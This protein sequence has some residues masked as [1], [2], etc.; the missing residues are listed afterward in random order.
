MDIEDPYTITIRFDKPFVAFGNK[1]T[2]GLFASVA[3][4]QSKK[5]IETAGEEGA[6]RQPVAPGPGNSSS[7]SGATVSSMRRWRTIGGRRPTS[8]GWCS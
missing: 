6:E 2:Q 8:S 1:V 7:T 3:F 5:Y 4:I